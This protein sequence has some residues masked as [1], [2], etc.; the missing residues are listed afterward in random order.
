MQD[1][2][3]PVNVEHFVDAGF[4]T[5]SRNP[6]DHE[7]AEAYR[8]A[9]RLAY[10]APPPAPAQPADVERVVMSL[11]FKIMENLERDV[12]VHELTTEELA[13]L[14]R[15]ALAAMP[16][17][18][19]RHGWVFF[20][21]DTGIE[22]ATSHPIESGEVPDAEDVRPATD[23]EADVVR[24]LQAALTQPA[25]TPPADADA[26]LVERIVDVHWQDLRAIVTPAPFHHNEKAWRA[27]LRLLLDK[28]GLAALGQGGVR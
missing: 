7:C 13:S 16:V 1:D 10:M 17:G 2:A 14:A 12:L 4:A 25:A 18:D 3:K 5:V 11:H 6:S 22:Y 8:E 27:M 24:Q 19:G 20:N 21:P 26:G 28:I 9:I 15:A 23:F